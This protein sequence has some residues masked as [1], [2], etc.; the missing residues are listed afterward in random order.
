[1]AADSLKTLAVAAKVGHLLLKRILRRAMAR[2]YLAA[3]RPVKRIGQ[4]TA[5]S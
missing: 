3:R 4:D 5:L 1:V 2:R